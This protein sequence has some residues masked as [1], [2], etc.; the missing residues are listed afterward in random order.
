MSLAQ[1]SVDRLAATVTACVALEAPSRS[2]AISKRASGQGGER[3]GVDGRG[4]VGS[5]A[6]RA[7]EGGIGGDS[8]GAQALVVRVYDALTGA[9]LHERA[10]P[11]AASPHEAAADAAREAPPLPFPIYSR[12]PL[13]AQRRHAAGPHAKWWEAALPAVDAVAVG[14]NVLA[15]SQLSMG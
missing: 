6:G 13:L 11:T 15:F 9:V 7:A 5:G 12:P 1:I 10:L 14:E 3:S 8:G 4:T 2:G